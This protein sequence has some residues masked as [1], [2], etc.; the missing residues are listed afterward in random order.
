MRIN[1]KKS[2]DNRGL[3]EIEKGE[4]KLKEIISPTYGVIDLG[5]IY[6]LSSKFIP[7]VIEDFSL[8]DGFVKQYCCCFKGL[9]CTRSA[10]LFIRIKHAAHV[11]QRPFSTIIVNIA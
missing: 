11:H 1:D 3:A 2:L 9:W 4:Q 7:G 8:I 6:T 10:K 5:F